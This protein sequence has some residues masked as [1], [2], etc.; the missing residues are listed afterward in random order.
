VTVAEIECGIARLRRQGATRRAEALAAWLE[1]LLHLYGKRVLA[2]DLATAR[3]AGALSDVVR[4]GGASPGF[5]DLAI[6]AMAQ[7]NC[8]TMLTGNTRHFRPSLS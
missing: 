6:A 5:A 7:A 8:L 3:L 1:A 2:F 4:A